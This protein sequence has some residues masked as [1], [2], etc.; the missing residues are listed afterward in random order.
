[1]EKKLRS[2]VDKGISSSDMQPIEES[3]ISI[4]PDVSRIKPLRKPREFAGTF[5]AVDCSTRTIK[6]ANNWGI[7]L[8]RTAYA[9][10]ERREVFWDYKETLHTAVG[11]SKTR[12]NLL[13]DDR[14]ELESQLA[15]N[16]LLKKP[17]EEAADPR[18]NYLLL[19]GG[20]YFGGERKFRVSLYEKCERIGLTLLAISKNSPSLHDEKGKDLIAAVSALSSYRTWVYHP[21]K[22]ADKGKSLYGDVSLVKLCEESPRVFRCDVME[23]L[24]TQETEEILSPL[25]AVSED[26]R[27]LGYPVALYLAHKFSAPSD[28]ALFTYHD[29]VEDTLANAGLLEELRQEELSCKFV[30]ELHGVR[31]AFRWEMVEEHV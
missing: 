6:R 28:A 25:T 15:L 24:K 10:T 7:Y 29:K 20:G 5:V 17:T 30:D 21:V 2:Y 23:Y 8:M 22:E 19:D 31:Y 11:D 12:G 13:K 4:K 18:N 14:I 16:I 9:S 3:G 27:Y 26:A 1:M